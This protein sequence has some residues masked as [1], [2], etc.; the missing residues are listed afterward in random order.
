MAGEIST[1]ALLVPDY[2]AAIAFYV[3][4][5]GF[6]LAEDRA[7]GES[8]RWVLL[9]PRRPGDAHLLLARAD[10]EAR[11]PGGGPRGDG[12]L[13][14]STDDF[15]RDH[16]AMLAAG[17]EFLDAPRSGSFGRRAPWRDP[18]GNRWTLI[19]PEPGG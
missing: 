13:V 4:K 6:A 1:I 12:A 17:I 19:G 18:F 2:D 9:A 8:R 7:L 3:G 16:S 15:D 10:A 11:P 5:M 14:L